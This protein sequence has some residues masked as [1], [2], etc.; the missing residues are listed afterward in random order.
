[1][2]GMPSIL[3]VGIGTSGQCWYRCALPARALG[4]D[5]VGVSGEPP[6]LTFH[7]GQATRLL[8]TVADFATYDIVV[9]QL[10]R[11]RAWLQAIRKLQAAGVKVLYEI[12][13]YAHGG[14]RT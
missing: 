6:A 7:T 9:L 10:V 3:F 5:W 14:L 11:G 1:M 8:R 12:D 4:A 2:S 13:D